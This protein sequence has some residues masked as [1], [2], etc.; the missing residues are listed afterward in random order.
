M[1][2]QRK[3]SG[4]RKARGLSQEE[5]AAK[6]HVVRQTVSKW[7][8]GLSVPD[9]GMLVRVAEALDTTV[10][11]LLDETAPEPEAQQASVQDLAAGLE[12]LS[13]QPARRSERKRKIWRA[14]FAAVG[15]C[16][17]AGLG[18]ALLLFLHLQQADNLPEASSSV[19]G[20]ADRPTSILVSNVSWD[21]LSA[22][23]AAC[24]VAIG[25]TAA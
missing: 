23:A 4:V 9:A 24:E 1:Y 2:A 20:R 25:G 19:I 11:A 6:L 21:G 15:L 3:H 10:S 16:A 17:L 5:L 14:A 7:E 13:G 8:K 18:R 12:L 22:L